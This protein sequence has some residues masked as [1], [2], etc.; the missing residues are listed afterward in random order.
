MTG[1]D[2]KMGGTYELMGKMTGL[3]RWEIEGEKN[4]FITTHCYPLKL[5][6]NKGNLVVD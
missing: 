6:G 4:I 5:C 1:I 3:S 2:G